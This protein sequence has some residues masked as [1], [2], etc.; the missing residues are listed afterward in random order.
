[1]KR[2][3][4]AIISIIM[5]I[6][7]T[8]S[9]SVGALA[10]IEL[11][12]DKELSSQLGISNFKLPYDDVDDDVWYYLPVA[13]VTS[14][15]LIE[16]ITSK[17]FIGSWNSTRAVLVHALWKLA[18]APKMSA[19]YKVTFQDVKSHKYLDAIKWATS[20]GIIKGYSD[21]EFGPDDNITREQTAVII[22]RYIKWKGLDVTLPDGYMMVA[23][24]YDKISSWALEATTWMSSIGLLR[25][26]GAG[27]MDPLGMVTRAEVATFVMRTY[28]LF[29]DIK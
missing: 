6:A 27:V 15:D 18:G 22:Y 1:M 13:F 8:L 2:R 25:G 19:D 5:I 14:Y 20:V 29:V 16:P 7:M 12:D 17:T 10:A 9:M 23:T 26:K 28:G 11:P 3:I 21:L 24:D 4:K